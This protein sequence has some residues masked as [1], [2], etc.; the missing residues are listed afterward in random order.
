VV[1][2][3]LDERQPGLVVLPAHDLTATRRLLEN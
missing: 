2:R 1:D 3:A